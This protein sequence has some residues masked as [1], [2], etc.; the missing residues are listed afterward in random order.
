MQPS[1]P[2]KFKVLV[3]A[4]TGASD[5]SRGTAGNPVVARTGFTLQQATLE[6]GTSRINGP[7]VA[8]PAPTA[9]AHTAAIKVTAP[10]YWDPIAIPP[11]PF[12][13]TE[14]VLAFNQYLTA[15]EEFGSGLGG[16][17]GPVATIATALAASLDNI[18]GIEAVAIADTVYI[19]SLRSEETLPIKATD[20]MSIVLGAVSFEVY[21]PGAVLLSVS[22]NYRQTFFVTK[23]SKSQSA[24]ISLP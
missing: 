5:P 20:D 24:P 2:P 7:S 1:F 11:P 15:G 12:Y 3:A 8:I 14:E 22:P 4:L 19:T 23:T 18:L 17:V 21:G 6:N 9:L 16:G 10:D 13:P